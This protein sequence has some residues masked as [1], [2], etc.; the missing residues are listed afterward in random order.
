MGRCSD[1]QN[2]VNPLLF[3]NFVEIDPAKK[4]IS[5]RRI[6]D[7]KTGANCPEQLTLDLLKRA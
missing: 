7:E 3:P 5:P 6:E 4:K 1:Y 2:Y